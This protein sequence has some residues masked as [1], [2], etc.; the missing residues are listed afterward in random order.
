MLHQPDAIARHA[1][2]RH[3]R[4]LQEAA[5][6]RVS[7]LA[8]ERPTGLRWSARLRLAGALRMIAMGLRITAD[9]NEGRVGS[10]RLHTRA[11]PGAPASL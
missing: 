6:E 5:D 2:A 1:H 9:R 8:L 3:E 11:E 7:Q 4:L 10:S